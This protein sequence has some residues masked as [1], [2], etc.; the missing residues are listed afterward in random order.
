MAVEYFC[1][2]PGRRPRVRH[3]LRRSRRTTTSCRLPQRRTPA[4]STASWCRT[5]PTASSPGSPRRPSPRRSA[6]HRGR[7][8][9]TVVRH[10][11]LRG[12]DGIDV[13]TV[14]RG[15]PRMA[16][17]ARRHAGHT[18]TRPATSCTARTRSNAPPSS[19]S[20]EGLSFDAPYTY[21]GQFFEVENGG[22][23]DPLTKYPAP[24]VFLSGDS[25]ELLQLSSP[26]ADVHV[27]ETTSLEDLSFLV[28]QLSGLATP[29][30]AQ[31]ARGAQP[32]GLGRRDGDFQG[33][34]SALRPVRL[35]RHRDLRAGRH[36]APG[37]GVL[38]QRR[39]L[40]LVSH[41]TA[42]GNPPSPSDSHHDRRPTMAID[43]YWRLP[44]HGDKGSLDTVTLTRGDWAPTDAGSLAPG[45]GP[46]PPTSPTSTTSL[47]SRR[48]G[49]DLRGSSVGLL[50]SFPPTD[51]PWVDLGR[52]RTRD[53]DLPLHDRVPARV[54]AARCTRRACRRRCSRSPAVGSSTTSSPVAVARVS[55]G[56]A[57]R[58]STTTAT[59]APRSSS[60][61]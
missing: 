30:R 60:M 53:Q 55:C 4:A 1:D 58:S 57:T 52:A 51:D 27:F 48:A 33:L 40:P 9:P 29:A 10:V 42:A 24:P 28:A 15:A 26:V 37:G 18:A 16:A 7:G 44:T 41:L 17:R 38:G 8:V 14:L 34:A 35:G 21:H 13:P 11:S 2:R 32:A 36:A 45:R 12:E 23:V 49:G 47:T 25:T 3:G 50:P 20:R 6:R 19:W 22:L 31:C 56:G 5:T 43:F 54:P 59:R 39:V 46:V 61:C